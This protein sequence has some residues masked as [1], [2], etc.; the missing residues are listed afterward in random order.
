MIESDE[1]I[2]LLIATGVLAFM[3]GHRNDLARIPR[4]GLLASSYL[5]LYVGLAATVAEGLFLPDAINLLEHVANTVSAFLLTGW[6]WALIRG[7]GK[8]AWPSS[9]R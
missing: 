2:A 9:V 4:A 5:A 3:I 6:L 7:K 1:L 8:D